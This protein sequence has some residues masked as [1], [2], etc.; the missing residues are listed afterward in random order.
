MVRM[1]AFM[2]CVFYPSEETTHTAAPAGGCAG[3]VLSSDGAGVARE[4]HSR[5]GVGRKELDKKEGHAGR[6]SKGQTT[7]GRGRAACAVNGQQLAVAGEGGGRRGREAV[8]PAGDRAGGVT[9]RALGVGPGG[10]ASSLQT[11]ES[12]K[13]CR[14]EV[15][16]SEV[17]LSDWMAG[18]PRQVVSSHG[19]V[20]LSHACDC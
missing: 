14:Q 11:Q 10:L 17:W 12:C 15:T 4:G 18:R 19:S 5:G 20:E 16:G 13:D 3:A 9:A 8:Q 1:A 7:R 2:L 6:G